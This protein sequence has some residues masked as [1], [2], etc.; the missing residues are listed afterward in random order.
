MAQQQRVAKKK[1]TAK[2][3]SR[4]LG[5]AKRPTNAK[6]A[7]EAA[8]RKH[9]P[10]DTVDV[11]DGYKGNIHILVVSRQFDRFSEYERQGVLRDI[12]ESSGISKDQQA[13]ISLLLAYSP[14]ELK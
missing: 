9:F 7:I 13:K 4:S 10:H 2:K 12:I 8:M 14:S 5:S 11:S 3:R 1:T 6:H